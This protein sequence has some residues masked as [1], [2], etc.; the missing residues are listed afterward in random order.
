MD[1]SDA[2]K[3]HCLMRERVGSTVTCN[4]IP[5]DADLDWLVLVKRDSIEPF[6][7]SLLDE[8]FSTD[9]ASMIDLAEGFMTHGFISL[10]LDVVNIIATS[11]DGFYQRFL[12]ATHVAKR[13]NLLN[14]QDRIALFQAVLYA[15]KWE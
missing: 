7:N 11:C 1:F 13:L 8:G 10:K 9:K 3:E 15:K 4:P 12:A 2:L 6:V 5:E 14:K